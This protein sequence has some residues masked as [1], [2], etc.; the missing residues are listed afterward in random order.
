M[1]QADVAMLMHYNRW[2]WDRVFAKAALVKQ[3]QYEALAPVPH[4]SLRGTLVH[5]LGAESTWRRRFAGETPTSLLPEVDLPRFEDL[6]A[7]WQIE[8][9]AFDSLIAN[10]SDSDLNTTLHYKTTRGVPMA[11]I[12]WRLIAHVVN[13]STQ[14]RSEAAMLLSTYGR[15]PGDLDMIVF[16]REAPPTP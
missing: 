11:D 5:A 16:L 3:D 10:L 1:N 2:A 8:A 12:L 7:R 4:G 13:H 14:H 6:K 9:D 15:S